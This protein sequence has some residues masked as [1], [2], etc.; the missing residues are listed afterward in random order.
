VENIFF[1]Q[2]LNVHGV[3]DSRQMDV[4]MAEPLV[5]EP[6]LIEMEIAIGKLKRCKSSATDQ[7]PAELI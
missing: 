1:N 5:P 3:H 2:L 6:S 4:Q 7:I